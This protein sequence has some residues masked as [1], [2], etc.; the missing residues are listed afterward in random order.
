MPFENS[1]RAEKMIENFLKEEKVMNDEAVQ[2][3]AVSFD[4]KEEKK[5]KKSFIEKLL[6]NNASKEF[7]TT[8]NS[9]IESQFSIGKIEEEL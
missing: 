2:F 4:K 5:E 6:N 1:E 8:W 9:W 7:I 3:D